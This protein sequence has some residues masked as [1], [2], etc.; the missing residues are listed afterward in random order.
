L[1]RHFELRAVGVSLAGVSIISNKSIKQG[2]RAA[3]C[4][5][6]FGMERQI[7]YRSILSYLILILSQQRAHWFSLFFFFCDCSFFQ[8]EFIETTF[9]SITSDVMRWVLDR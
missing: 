9:C 8:W 3:A 7:A 1:W 4:L 5:A 2:S 6:L